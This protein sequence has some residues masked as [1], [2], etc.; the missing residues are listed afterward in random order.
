MNIS[1]CRED[2][3]RYSCLH[4]LSRYGTEGLAGFRGPAQRARHCVL[5]RRKGVR[6]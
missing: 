1:S 6:L 3:F 5:G 2:V 4:Q